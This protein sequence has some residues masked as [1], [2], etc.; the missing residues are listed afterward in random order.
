MNRSLLLDVT[1]KVK[2]NCRN[3]FITCIRH[4][5]IQ[6]LSTAEEG[7]IEYRYRFLDETSGTDDIIYLREIWRDRE[8]WNRHKESEHFR[9]LQEIK[10]KYIEETQIKEQPLYIA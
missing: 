1:Y 2:T 6:E 9:K 3:D 5:Q 10:E 4:E 8:S 7:N